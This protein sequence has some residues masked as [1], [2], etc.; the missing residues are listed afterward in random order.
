MPKGG[1][2]TKWEG[3]VKTITIDLD[4]KHKITIKRPKKGDPISV[5]G[6]ERLDPLQIDGNPIQGIFPDDTV[7][8][9]HTNPICGYYYW[10]GK[11]YY[12]CI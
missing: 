5:E 8:L 3:D 2:D 11:W 6:A 10:N 4:N 1:F 9:T 7:I 12:R